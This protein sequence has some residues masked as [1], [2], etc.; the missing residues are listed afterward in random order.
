[1]LKGESTGFSLAML[2]VDPQINT[3]ELIKAYFES[4]Q[5][6]VASKD[7]HPLPGVV[8]HGGVPVADVGCCPASTMCLCPRGSLE[9]VCAN[10]QSLVELSETK[11]H[12]N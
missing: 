4:E 1:M 10:V 3:K 9:L 2:A 7:I 6:M 12:G 5:P 8:H 11:Y